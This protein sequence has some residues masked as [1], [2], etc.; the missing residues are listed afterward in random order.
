MSAGV[1]IARARADCRA[2]AASS[3]GAHLAYL[4]SAAT[5]LRPECV[6]EAMADVERTTRGSAGRG[7][8]RGA[9]LQR[10]RYETARA[11]VASFLRAPAPREVIFT[12][13]TTDGIHLVAKSWAEARLAPGDELVVSRLEHHANLL[14]WQRVCAR[15]GAKLLVWEPD[16]DGITSVDAL[17]R[18][19]TSRTRLVCFAHVSNVVGVVNDVPRICALARAVGAK[20]LVDGAQAV[21]H[22][23][24]DV[25]ALGCDFYAFSAHKLYGPAGF[26]ALWARPECLQ[27]MQPE[28]LGGGIVR[29][30][31]MMGASF[32]EPPHCFEAGTPNVAG[33]VGLARAIDWL[34][35]FG[36]GRVEQ[37]ERAL[38]RKAEEQLGALERVRLLGPRNGRSALVSFVVDG[39]HPHDL[40]SWLDARGVAV[41]AG[42]LCAQPAHAHFGVDASLRASFGVYSDCDDVDALLD[43][44]ES[45]CEVLCP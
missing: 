21:A 37:H 39:A 16:A 9:V 23:P 40:S 17:S 3:D 38:A 6:I 28:Q 4:D 30:V 25:Q 34:E 33:A 2:L 32:V 10:E 1:D 5:T 20:V 11:R 7:A 26:G 29:S 41:R 14:P 8:Q 35:T 18:V 36:R 24:L 19:L 44:V 13:G 27:Q 43:A 15:T 42:H 31:S 12:R 45:A 22:T